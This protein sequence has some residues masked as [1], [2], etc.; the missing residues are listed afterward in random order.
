[1][2]LQS[3]DQKYNESPEAPHSFDDQFLGKQFE[4][5]TKNYSIE[6][7][8]DSKQV[9]GESSKIHIEPRNVAPS[10]HVT[11]REAPS[12]STISSLFA[13]ENLGTDQFFSLSPSINNNLQVIESPK[14]I[15]SVGGEL[16]DYMQLFPPPPKRLSTAS[17]GVVNSRDE[18]SPSSNSMQCS[19]LSEFMV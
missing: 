10:F 5:R 19:F 14:R 15:F 7:N 12:S 9:F 3:G 2:P 17:N 6:Q 13:Q 1:M 4:I 11:S 18:Q 16:E 8:P